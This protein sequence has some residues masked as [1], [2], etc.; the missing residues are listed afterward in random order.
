MLS[1]GDDVSTRISSCALPSASDWLNDVRSAMDMSD[2]DCRVA[3]RLR[4]GFSLSEWA[5][6][7]CPLCG[8]DMRDS[9]NHSLGRV[10]QVATRRHSQ[11]AS[12]LPESP[13]SVCPLEPL[14]C[15]RHPEDRILPKYQIW[16]SCLQIS[17]FWWMSLALT[18]DTI[19]TSMTWQ[20]SPVT[21]WPSA[22]APSTPSI[23]GAI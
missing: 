3:V 14:P 10:R 1:C 4:L 17:L 23:V 18:P 19:H 9:P 22:Q 12:Q 15:A 20:S 13:C 16:I 6:P 11:V 21:L 7:S 8:D 2:N 5:Q